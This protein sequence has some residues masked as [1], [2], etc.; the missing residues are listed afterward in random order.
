MGVLSL[1]AFAVLREVLQM[2][3]ILQNGLKTIY[4]FFSR[5]H[6]IMWLLDLL[7]S[8]AQSPPK[9][10]VLAKHY[11]LLG[12]KKS[13]LLLGIPLVEATQNKSNSSSIMM[14]VGM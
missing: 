5:S 4:P 14:M 9:E 3:R 12:K 8:S 7:N 13:P 6:S 10:L 2:P 1:L 11:F